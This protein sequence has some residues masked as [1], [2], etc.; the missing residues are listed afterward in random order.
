MSCETIWNI[1]LSILSFV[2]AVVSVWIAIATLRQNNRM[3]ET[4][5]R[6]SLVVLFIADTATLS[7][8]IKNNGK[9]DAIIESVTHDATFKGIDDY[10]PFKNC[11]GAV[12]SPGEYLQYTEEYGAFCK[13]N[14][15][16]IHMR[17]DYKSSA[18]QKYVLD[19][20]YSILALRNQ[21]YAE[22]QIT[23]KNASVELAKNMQRLNKT[24][25]VK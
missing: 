12:I 1:V 4:S 18:G 14:K 22:T 7:I 6:P 2:L 15:D 8:V 16:T 17:I 23:D 11:N 3:L 10:Y 21:T 25:R 13:G 19:Q 20:N 24:L 9:T 5:T